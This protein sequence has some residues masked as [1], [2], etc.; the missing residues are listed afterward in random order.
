V[1]AA[2]QARRLDVA[3]VGGGMAGTLLARQLKRARPSLSVAVFEKSTERSYKV[4]ESLVEIA[5]NYLVRRHRLSG[6]LYENH[7]PKNGL[8][9][10][11][12]D[13]TCSTPLTEMSEVG[14]IN[15]PFHPAFQIDRA[16]LETDLLRMIERQGVE[17]RTGVRVEDL[18]L[19]E[20]GTEHRFVVRGP[21]GE[22][23]YA[24]RWLIDASGR[25]GVVA[26]LR[27][28]R[29][30]ET[31]HRVGSVWA[32]FR[33]V[34]DAD[35][36]GCEA[37]RGRVRHSARRLS[38]MHFWYP[39]YWFW[40]IPLRG[41]ITSVGLTGAVAR[42]REVRTAEGFRA[43]LRRHRAIEQ[44][45][46]GAEMVDCG[47][48]SQIAFGTKRFFHADRWGLTGEAATAA[49]P[50]YSPG[51]DFIALENDFLADLIERDFGGES[52]ETLGERL[53]LYERFMH[54]RHESAMLLYRGLYDAMGSF[55]LMRMKWDLDIGCYYNLWVSPYMTDQHLDTSFL[56]R[57]LR[58][59]PFV[60]QALRNFADLFRRVERSLRD[61]GN[62]FRANRGH[63]NYGLENIDFVEEIGSPRSRRVV[64]EKTEEIFNI[65]LAR[66]V[67]L[68]G[69]S[70]RDERVPLQSFM[71]EQPLA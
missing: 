69:E 66:A 4:G 26:K 14:P 19:G 8:R 68:L 55:E 63:F 21:D 54:F 1:S 20:G 58:M 28:L 44:L 59:Q 27:D 64:L 13:E 36:I 7:L 57:Q 40:V 47:S 24:S 34:A 61:D 45:L 30:P 48:F 11:F 25:A 52:A 31:Q 51:S 43:F 62:Y 56:R 49:D 29:V 71:G 67:E 42:D 50:F 23:S 5:A 41:G 32:R 18:E 17:V 22:D 2:G 46:G 12:D 53:D 6:Y 16:R 10:F 3:V 65:V 37:W 70:A 39:G 38:T 35:E 9:Y 60:L 33:G 15:L